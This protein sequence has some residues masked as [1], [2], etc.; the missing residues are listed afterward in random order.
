MPKTEIDY[1]NTIIYKITCKDSEIKDVY[2]GH[3][4][5]FVQRK[6]AHKQ[7]CN[8]PKTPNYDCKLYNTIREKGGWSNWKMEIINFFNCYDHYEARQKEQEYFISLNA[9]LNSIEPMPKPKVKQIH[10]CDICNI[11][12]HTLKGLEHHNETSKHK[13]RLENQQIIECATNDDNLGCEKVASFFCE[14]CAFKCSRKWMYARHIET[15]KHQKNYNEL[16]E[17]CEKVLTIPQCNCGKIYKHRQGLWKHQQV[18]NKKQDDNVLI[19]LVSEVVKSNNEIQR[20]NIELQ[21]QTNELQKQNQE[22][23]KQILEVCKNGII[24]NS[25]NNTIN[26]NNKT[27]NLQV[28]LNEDCKD[29]MN[30]TDFVNSI[31]LQLSDLESVG[32]LGYVEGISNIIIKNLKALDVTKRPVHCTDPK[33]ETIYIKDGDVWEKD[34]E[35]NK[36]LRKMIRSVAF[37]N[38]KNTRLFKEKYPDC[39]RYDSKYSDI[40][41]KIIIEVMG[42][43]PKSNDIENQNKIMRKIAKEMTIDKN[44]LS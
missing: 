2:V 38:C 14:K 5:N 30:I 37:R 33:R 39:T 23:Q 28:F 8:N 13:K 35:D 3:T 42:G 12:C 21:K 44:N 7:S 20:Q 25:N 9:N 27:F 17:S 32:K 11:K 43:G 41:N 6:H 31:Q 40:Y 1:S 29:A 34:D 26:S 18:C 19:T 16:Q 36:K 15:P 10:I 4:T 22:M 24:N